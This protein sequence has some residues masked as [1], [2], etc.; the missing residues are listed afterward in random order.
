MLGWHRVIDGSGEA[1][2]GEAYGDAEDE[3]GDHDAGGILDQ[4]KSIESE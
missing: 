2:G 3:A 1:D 4:F